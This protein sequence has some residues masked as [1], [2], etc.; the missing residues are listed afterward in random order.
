MLLS[1]T[2]RGSVC[3]V[4]TRYGR[5]GRATAFGVITR[6]VGTLVKESAIAGTIFFRVPLEAYF[7]GGCGRITSRMSISTIVRVCVPGGPSY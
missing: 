6:A 1:S 4:R 7:R 2:N 3:V 5:S